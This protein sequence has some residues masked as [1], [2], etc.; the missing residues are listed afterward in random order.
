[1]KEL[2]KEPKIFL[3]WPPN[4]TEE[5]K[6]KTNVATTYKGDIYCPNG[7]VRDDV[8]EHE[9]KH[10]EQYGDD[11]DGWTTRCNEDDD[12]LITQEVEAYK[13]QAKF[14]EQ[15]LGED[16]AKQALVSF[17]RFLSGLTYGNIISFKEAFK[18][19]TQ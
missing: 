4:V 5:D 13:A 17:A 12:F 11:Y 3:K 2:K 1:M 10:I 14:I 16:K 7:P 8:I 18:R 9:K 19:L 15:T 6:K